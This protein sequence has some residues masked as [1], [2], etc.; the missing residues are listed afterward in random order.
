[1]RILF[2]G[3][4]DFAKT[5]LQAIHTQ[6]A[7]DELF[8]LSAPARP[9]GRGMTLTQPPVAA[10]A[11]ERDLPL[12]QPETLKNEA[13]L[14]VLEEIRP[15]VAIVAAY[16]K[17]LPAYFIDFP[18]LGCMNVHAS[19]LP[20]YRGASPIQRSIWDCH[21][22]TGVTIMQMDY[23]LDTGDILLQKAVEI[24]TDDNTLTLTNKLADCGA[25]LICEALR[26]AG[27]G[28]LR[29]TPQDDARATYAAKLT[30]EDERLNFS[31]TAKEL[32]CKIR[33]LAPAP[34]AS[35][36]LPNGAEM[37]V[38]AAKV[39]ENKPTAPCGTIRTQKSHVFVA[40]SGSE[41]E[42]LRVKPQG[43]GEM[44]AASLVNGRKLTHGD[45]LR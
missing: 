31:L 7:D 40:C 3:T 11:L 5:V 1:M 36:L 33:A 10:Y 20:L 4:P 39:T 27:A 42:L 19:L 17:I 28:S 41:L 6:F 8:V 16:G 37:K 34:L 30:R 32:D 26:E 29:R 13:F 35:V 18:R 25:A 12:Y 21:T 2:C 24:R 22:E 45:V 14:P 44:D 38:C 23:G 9:K 43:K 15:D